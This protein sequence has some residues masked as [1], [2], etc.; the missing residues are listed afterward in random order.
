MQTILAPVPLKAKIT[1]E[2][3]YKIKSCGY[4]SVANKSLFAA[5]VTAKNYFLKD[6]EVVIGKY[7]HTA[8]EIA[9]QKADLPDEGYTICISERGI[10]VACGGAK[11]AFYAFMTLRQL[12]RQYGNTLPF[13]EIEDK[14]YFAIRGYMLDISRN[15][16][17]T[18]SRLK[19][20]ADMLCE[21]KINHLELYVEGAPFRFRNHKVMWEETSVL[22]GEEIA[23][24]DAYCA[25]RF[26]ELVPTQNTFGHMG[27]WLTDREEYNRLA[28]CP[29]GF[30]RPKIGD[31]VPL[32]LC[33]DPTDPD[34]FALVEDLSNDLLA[35]F[36][37]DKYNVCC[38][39]T[40]ELGL[41]KSKALADQIGIGRVYLNYL[42]K[43]Y[44]YCR[45][46][47]KTMMFWAD[48]INEYPEL[49]PEIPKDVI[50]L[51]WGYYDDLPR[52]DSCIAFEKSGVPY[53][54]CPG[55]AVWNTLVGHT[56]Q[57][58]Q[59]VHDTIMKGY[60]H[61]AVGVV[62]T[63]WGDN[64]HMQGVAPAYP[65]IVYG[66]AMSWQPLVNEQMDLPNALNIHIFEDRAK[67]MGDF[68]M[69][70][71]RYVALEARTFENTS[72][73][74]RLLIG[75]LDDDTLAE[76]LKESDLDKIDAFLS[77]FASKIDA[78]D[79]ACADAALIMREYR[80]N[81]RMLKYALN[82]GRYI[83]RK[84]KA[85]EIQKNKLKQISKEAAWIVNELS[86]TWLAKNKTS[87]LQKSLK[88]FI[89]D[90][91][92]ASA[93]LQKQD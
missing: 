22:T 74:F 24:F 8:P 59:N 65:A 79:M 53:C 35:Y 69:D 32:S 85:N 10:E 25:A 20:I 61:S 89:R 90:I 11:G 77:A 83:L 42:L 16:I 4:I 64:G 60:R 58:L 91:N 44:H 33:L 19:E 52:E 63:D 34:A 73:T 45:K 49:V 47:G 29:N 2:N 70:I 93:Q 13:A 81:I 37:S 76:N 14:P 39:E 84:K 72:D 88:V 51:N 50:A 9:V 15:K 78:V 36:T 23:V 41:G 26:I 67:M 43:L 57:M 48:I 12:H 80:L 1:I 28:E 27:T 71:G 82:K 6:H 68:A 92:Y 3:R 40:L 38:D 66:A 46:N 54:V 5:C 86:E 55:S 87:R 75:A 17:P 62:T 18:L 31:F 21:L 30:I 56:E 7:L